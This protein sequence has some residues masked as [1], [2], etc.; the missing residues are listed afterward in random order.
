MR[1]RSPSSRPRSAA[2]RG[3]GAAALLVG[4]FIPGFAGVAPPLAATFGY[5]AA[6]FSVYYG[7]GNALWAGSALIVGLA[8][9]TQID[10]LMARVAAFGAPA[11]IA[12]AVLVGLYVAYRWLVRRHFLRSLGPRASA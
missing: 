5:S 6:R 4:K 8:F 9:R 10:W 3:Y 7:V 12:V 11:L 2:C 1:S